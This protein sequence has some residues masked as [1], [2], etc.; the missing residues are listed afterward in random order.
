MTQ[1]HM[2]LKNHKAHKKTFSMRKKQQK[3]KATN[4]DSKELNCL[5]RKR[6]RK[7]ELLD[8]VKEFSKMTGHKATIQ[9]LIT[10]LQTSSQ[11]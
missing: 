6:K 11:K 5:Q 3:Q 2:I 9:K 7:E 4:S 8:L 10:V 1:E